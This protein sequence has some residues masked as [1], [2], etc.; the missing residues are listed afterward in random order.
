MTN[1]KLSADMAAKLSLQAGQSY[2]NLGGTEKRAARYHEV[3]R[4]LLFGGPTESY[5]LEKKLGIRHS[6]LWQVLDS[7]LKSGYIKVIRTQQFR[8]GV[9]RTWAATPKGFRWLWD[10]SEMLHRR[11]LRKEDIH[12]FLIE[13]N[14]LRQEAEMILKRQREVSPWASSQIPTLSRAEALRLLP[15]FVD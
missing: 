1:I 3:L 10:G 9:K 11:N 14:E 5:Q 15:Y 8:V 6:S 7:L 12:R 4:Q 13:R 2:Q